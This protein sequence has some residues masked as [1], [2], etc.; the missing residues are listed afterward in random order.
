MDGADIKN[1]EVE[2]ADRMI[3]S[4]NIGLIDVLF[5]KGNVIGGANGATDENPAEA[6]ARAFVKSLPAEV[7]A[8]E[9]GNQGK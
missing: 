9:T 8:I 3:R 5:L 4:A 7:T 6:F 1:L 2:G